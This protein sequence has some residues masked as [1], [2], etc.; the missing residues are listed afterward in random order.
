MNLWRNR[1]FSSLLT[2]SIMI[3]MRQMKRNA[4]RP[5]YFEAA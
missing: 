3:P 2:L 5:M 4:Q 1:P